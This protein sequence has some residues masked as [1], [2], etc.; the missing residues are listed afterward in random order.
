MLIHVH[1]KMRDVHITI[2]DRS[3]VDGIAQVLMR[4][5]GIA[6][7]DQAGAHH[8]TIDLVAD[9]GADADGQIMRVAGAHQRLGNGLRIADAGKAA[10]ADRHAGM[11]QLRRLICRHDLAFQEFRYSFHGF[12]L[13]GEFIDGSADQ[14]RSALPCS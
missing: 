6:L 10:H 3:G 4:L 9:G 5:V 14:A 2:A 7:F 1:R 11:D 8:C 13:I 12:L